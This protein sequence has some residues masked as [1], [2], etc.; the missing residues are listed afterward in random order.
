MLEK[1]IILKG[2]EVVDIL[3]SLEHYKNIIQFSKTG[4]YPEKTEMVA[5]LTG[6]LEKIK[7]TPYHIYD[8]N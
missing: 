6:L 4:R 3:V 1:R 5:Q 8:D 2:G 7:N